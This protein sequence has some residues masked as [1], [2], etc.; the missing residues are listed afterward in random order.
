MIKYIVL[1]SVTGFCFGLGLGTG[2]LQQGGVAKTEVV[3]EE[4]IVYKTQQPKTKRYLV[5][6]SNL[7]QRSG[8]STT[9]LKL[10]LIDEGTIVESDL[11]VD[12]WVRYQREEISYWLSENY[13]TEVE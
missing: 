11:Q 13:L 2:F 8:P 3:V 9:C 7:N 12:G 1:L 10:G 4:K 5:N 6:A